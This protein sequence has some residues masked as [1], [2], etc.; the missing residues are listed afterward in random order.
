MRNQRN[1]VK[2]LLLVLLAATAF[3]L[4]PLL[5][6]GPQTEPDTAS[7]MQVAATLAETGNFSKI[8][9][10]SGKQTPYAYRMPLFHVMIAGLIKIFGPEAAWPLAAVNLL[11]SVLTVMSAVLFFYVLS[12]PEIA[13]AAGY[14]AA[15]NPNAAFNSLLLLNDSL[16]AFLSALMLLA[17]LWALKRRTGGVFFLWGLSIGLCSMVRPIMKFYWAAPLLLVFTPFFRAAVKEKARLALLCALGAASLLVPWSLRNLHELGFFG[18]EL[19]QG[20]NTL[21]STSDLV[22]PS[23]PEEYR[24]DPRLAQMRDIT[25]SSPSPLDAEDSIRKVMRLPMPEVN[26][27]MTRLGTE[28]ILRNP[29]TFFIRVLRN[30]MNITTSPNSVME[31]AGR[32]GGKGPGYFPDIRTALRGGYRA[33]IAVNLG[34][35][36]ALFA[37]CWILAPLGALL[38]WRGA[39]EDGKIKLLLPVSLI[40]YTLFLT[41]LVAGY[42]R[43][44][45]PLDPLLLG[46]AAAWLLSKFPRPGAENENSSH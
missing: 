25:A 28:T 38:L 22:K 17:G 35:R 29:R 36:L 23:T 8:D 30:L 32:L 1:F 16:F 33:A 18:L 27:G 37:L 31:L 19:N 9:L 2:N 42:D 46:F 13:L 43:Y 20:V 45:L 34:P 14:L 11:L 5:I 24:A 26:A 39:G 44:R 6:L 10:L 41:P 21:W 3:R 40:L 4:V 12:G 7:Y 15:L